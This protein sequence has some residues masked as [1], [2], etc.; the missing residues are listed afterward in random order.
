MSNPMRTQA[1]AS[2]KVKT[3]KVDARVLAELG[4]ADFI[5]PVWSPDAE[6]IAL[7]RRV[8]HRASLAD[9]EFPAA[10][11]EGEAVGN[12]Q[13]VA[14]DLVLPG[15]ADERVLGRDRLRRAAAPPRVA[16]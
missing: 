12:P 3:D 9:R 11:I 1:I 16:S 10:A 6:T 13:A 7:R 15:G 4:A 5:P 2:A 14:P 8:A